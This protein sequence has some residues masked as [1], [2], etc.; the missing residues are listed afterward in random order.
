MITIVS[1]PPR[2]GKTAFL[3][4]QACNVA[5]DHERTRAMQSALINKVNNGFTAIRTIPNHCVSSNYDLVMRKFGYSP[6]LSRR[7]NPYRLGFANTDVDVHFNLPYEAIFITEAQKYLNS[8]M[9]AYFPAWQSRWYEQHGHNNLDIWL[10]TQRPN[11]IDVNIRE[12]AT[13]IEIVKLDVRYDTNGNPKIYRWTIRTIDNSGMY[14]RYLSSGKTDKSTFVESVVKTDLNVFRMYDHQSCKPK[15]YE[16]HL[17]ADIDYIE[18]EP[19]ADTFD[20]YVRY[21]KQFDDE[22]PDNFYQTRSIKKND[23]LPQK[24]TNQRMLDKVL[25]DVSDNA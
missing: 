4:F 1:A 15:F 25:R 10:D 7:I 14:D 8:R 16:G 20:D 13:F 18:S 21:L 22:L 11:L 19:P 17:D 23:K 5:F 9:S 24:S 12:L 3:T 2:T 6:R